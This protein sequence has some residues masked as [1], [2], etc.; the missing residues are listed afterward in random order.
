MK[1]ASRTIVDMRFATRLKCFCISD[2][3]S[4][5]RLKLCGYCKIWGFPIG[6]SDYSTLAVNLSEIRSVALTHGLA[7]VDARIIDP[8]FPK[9]KKKER[10][11]GG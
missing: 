11:S 7:D 6:I 8:R 10:K 4:F 1:D 2:K 5:S 9:K 3:F